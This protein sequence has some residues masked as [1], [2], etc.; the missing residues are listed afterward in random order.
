MRRFGLDGGDLSLEEQVANAIESAV[1]ELPPAD[2]DAVEVILGLDPSTRGR[3]LGV[4][5][6]QAA[7]ILGVTAGTF[8]NRQE[9]RL[10]GELAR[11]IT[12]ILLS[13]RGCSASLV[14]GSQPSS[15]KAYGFWSYVRRVLT[16]S[17]DLRTQYKMRTAEELELF[18]DR[19]SAKWGEEWEK[20]ISDA[21]AG[22]TFFIPIIT[23][24]YFRSNAC[25]QELLKFVR[26]ADKTGLERLL[27]PVYWITVP[28]L[29]SE[30][31]DSVDEAVGAVARHQ[32][33]DLR[34]VRLE[35]QVSSLYRKAVDGLAGD[36]AARASEVANSIDDLPGSDQLVADTLEEFDGDDL[37][38]LDRLVD[39]DEAMGIMIGVMAGIGEDIEL[40]GKMAS[41]VAN[42]VQE[43][44][45][46]H[47]GMKRALAITEKFA[48]ELDAPASRLEERGK[49]YV[50]LL[51]RLDSA[52]QVRFDVFTEQNESLT[53]TQLHYLAE[54]GIWPEPP[55]RRSALLM[56][57]WIASIS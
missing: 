56:I 42:Q 45:G 25:R 46:Q 40:I 3:R 16:L 54:L 55:T 50:G 36:I 57:L 19:E 52:M 31:V 49:T 15:E 10:L 23:P 8:R 32:W 13:T 27:M 12:A 4:R 35:D 20:L 34:D 21:I 38:L 9:A 22:T 18:V 29:E 51:V 44:Q 24:S 7:E 43:A 48:G 17:M 39:G 1:G 11:R 37:G 30:G 28:A 47:Q 5:R 2:K 53:E 14:K 41:N 6:E 33:Q 26:G